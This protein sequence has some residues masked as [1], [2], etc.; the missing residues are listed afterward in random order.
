MF[1]PTPNQTKKPPD[2][3]QMKTALKLCHERAPFSLPNHY[4]RPYASGE[5]AEVYA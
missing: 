1:H 4:N 3:R 5:I 2:R